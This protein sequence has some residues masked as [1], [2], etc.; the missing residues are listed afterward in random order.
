M[1]HIVRTIAFVLAV[2]MLSVA[3]FAG[4]FTPSVEQKPAPIPVPPTTEV[5]GKPAIVVKDKEDT[6]VESD[7]PEVLVVIPMSEAK[8]QTPEVKKEMEEAYTEIAEAES[9]TDIAP[10][11]PEVMKEMDIDTPAEDLVVRDVIKLEVSEKLAESLK[12]EG[13]T[14]EVTFEMV[15]E[16]GQKLIIMVKGADGQWIVLPAENVTVND[17]GTVTIAFTTVGMVAFVVA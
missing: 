5:D 9:L 1:K 17:D 15:L 7:D 4:N 11:L 2:S 8:D 14:L 16:E 3:A 10:A 12:E 6:I 13:N